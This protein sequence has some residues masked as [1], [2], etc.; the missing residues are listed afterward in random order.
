MDNNFKQNQQVQTLSTKTKGLIEVTREKIRVRHFSLFTEKQYIFW[1]RK[2]V[3]FHK[4]RHPREMGETE[5]EQFLSY[6]AVQKDVA[7]STQ[8]QAL[9]ALVF[10][11]RH[12]IEKDLGKFTKIRWAKKKLHIPVVL[13]RKEVAYILT[14]FKKGTQQKLIAHLLYGCGLRLTEALNLRLKD[15]DFG[16]RIIVIREAKGG[17]DRSVPLPK[18]LEAPLAYQIKRSS[19]IHA[20]DLKAG[21]GKASLP[22]ALCRKYPNAGTSPLWQY[23]FPSYKLSK[24]PRTGETKRHHLYDSIMEDSLR[25]A[26]RIAKIEKRVNCH[27]FRHSYATHLLE[28]GK[29]IRTIQTLLGHSDVKT[30]MIYTH[31]AK[32]PAPQCESPLDLLEFSHETSSDSSSKIIKESSIVL[33]LPQKEEPT[34]E[35]VREIQAA[36]A[37]TLKVDF[38]STDSPNADLLKTESQFKIENKSTMNNSLWRKLYLSIMRQGKV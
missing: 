27:T 38:L 20:L 30:T 13:T 9:N 32:G 28:S 24:D 15:I 37:S 8:N 5:I 7:P 16:Q 1:I 36:S 25:A 2:F 10:L 4:K 12:V 18:L 29:D 11:F 35:L 23:V 17:K 31:V 22:Y 21:F 6:L 19:K 3:A 14:S 34:L 26:V 33:Q